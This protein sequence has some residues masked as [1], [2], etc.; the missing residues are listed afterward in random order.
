M[1]RRLW[2]L[3]H[4]YAGLYLAFFV[5][6]TGLTGSILAFD[7]NIQKWLNPEIDT[8][9]LQSQEPLDG[10]SLRERAQ[11]IEPRARFQYVPLG[12][13]SNEVRYFSAEPRNDPSTGHPYE[14]GYVGLYLDPYTGK[15][16][17]RERELQSWPITRQNVMFDIFAVHYSLACGNAGRILLGIAAIVWTLDCFV[18]FALTL[19]R[20]ERGGQAADATRRSWFARWWPSWKFA[21]RGKA[22]RW[23]FSFHRAA[24]LWTWI[25]LFAFAASSVHFNLPEVYQ[26]VM[27]HLFRMP[28]VQSEI[29]E[30]SQPIPDPALGWRQAAEVGQRLAREQSV[31]CGFKLRESHSHSWF[32]Y[33]PTKG[34]FAYPVHTDGDVGHHY[35]GA[36]IF[37]DGSDGAFR[38]IEFASGH[39]LATTFT[40][41]TSAIHNCTVGGLPMQ[42]VTSITGL[43]SAALSVTGVYLWWMKRRTARAIGNRDAEG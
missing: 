38:G 20:T 3:V 4:R 18:G 41:W 8:V 23:N 36:T 11:A 28:D 19:P 25:L 6:V 31:H 40:S 24:G 17:A 1:N 12:G 32:F 7:G 29:P 2:V 21:W 5:T 39:S 34:I 15:E 42:I 27:K 37:F 10:F 30:L 22:Y 13:H 14:L 43:V 26:P 9:P 35:V 33:D 16:I